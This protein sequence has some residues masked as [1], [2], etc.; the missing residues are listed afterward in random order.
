MGDDVENAAERSIN[1]TIS[2]HM[3]PEVNPRGNL[4]LGGKLFSKMAISNDDIRSH[5]CSHLSRVEEQYGIPP[6][7][8]MHVFPPCK[9]IA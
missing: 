1:N 4:L 8:S 2:Q 6:G 7:F 9:N 5:I 3:Y